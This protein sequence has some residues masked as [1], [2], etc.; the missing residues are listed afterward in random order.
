M[1]CTLKGLYMSQLL[2]PPSPP[3]L[4]LTCTYGIFFRVVSNGFNLCH[5]AFYVCLGFFVHGLFFFFPKLKNE[6]CLSMRSVLKEAPE[7]G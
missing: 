4:L 3:L 1:L 6:T 5:A 2:F 7:T